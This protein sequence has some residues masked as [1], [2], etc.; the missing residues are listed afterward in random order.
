MQQFII[1][2]DELRTI[3]TLAVKSARKLEEANAVIS[4]VVSQH[5]WKCPERVEID[6]SLETIKTN[7]LELRNSFDDLSANI[8][9]IA[10]SCTDFI[11]SSTQMNNSYMQDLAGC[12][13]S[14]GAVTVG[15]SKGGNLAKVVS[16]L[17]KNSLDTANIASLHGAAVATSIV[18]LPLISGE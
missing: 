14:Q 9:T 13:F 12:L 6:E 15:Q 11:N 8:T 10:N 7:A 1:D 2:V 18:D 5:D 4:K 17:E 3:S 16:A